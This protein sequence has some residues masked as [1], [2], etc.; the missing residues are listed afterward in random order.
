MW[1]Y[2]AVTPARRCV[3]TAKACSFA[4]VT[5]DGTRSFGNLVER[6]A[7]FPSRYRL[8]VELCNAATALNTNYFQDSR[9]TM[10]EY[11]VK[12]KCVE[13]VCRKWFG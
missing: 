10:H 7:V 8:S 6:D 1:G 11:S 3:G 13:E 12:T 9:M 4:S 5:R 2:G